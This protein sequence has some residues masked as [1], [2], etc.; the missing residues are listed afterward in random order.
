MWGNAN[1]GI[2]WANEASE[3]VDAISVLESESNKMEQEEMEARMAKA[4]AK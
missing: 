4:K 1:G 3:Y 2:G